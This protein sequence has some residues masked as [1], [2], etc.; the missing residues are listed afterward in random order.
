MNLRQEAL[1]ALKQTEILGEDENYMRTFIDAGSSIAGM[2]KELR[3]DPQCSRIY[4]DRLLKEFRLIV[5]ETNLGLQLLVEPLSNRVLEILQLLDT[6]MTSNEV[7]EALYIAVSTVRVH[8][9]HIY[10]KLG[11]SRRFEAV[12]RAKELGLI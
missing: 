2:L 7:A 11:V 5:G 4:I 9:K 6:S 8:I 10:A 1:A 3:S 12:R